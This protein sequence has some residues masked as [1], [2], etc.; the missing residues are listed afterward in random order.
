MAMLS[1]E[2]SW[3]MEVEYL[4]MPGGRRVRRE[5]RLSRRSVPDDPGL[6]R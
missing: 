3:V 4:S 5:A 6:A 1:P 2:G